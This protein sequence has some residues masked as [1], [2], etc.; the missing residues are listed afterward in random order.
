MEV[1]L[2]PETETRI[3]ELAAQTGRA[4]D[5]LVEDAMTV[6]LQEISEARSM[7]DHRYDDVRSGRVKPVDGEEGFN[8]LKRKSQ[9][10]RRS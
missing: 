3:Q 10:R 1:H 2:R 5:E 7:L 4:A 6:Y 9:E 8:I